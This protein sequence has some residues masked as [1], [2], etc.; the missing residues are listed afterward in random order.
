MPLKQGT[1]PD[2]IGENIAEL[3]RSGHSPAQAAAIAYKATQGTDRAAGIAYRAGLG[4]S[5]HLGI[6]VRQ[7]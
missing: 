5:A 3:V 1:T 7:H 6:P 4:L 2:V